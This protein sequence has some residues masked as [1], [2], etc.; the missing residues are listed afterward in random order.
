[1]KK[2]ISTI[3]A[4]CALTAALTSCNADSTAINVITR[5]EGSGTRGAFVELLEVTDASGVDAIIQSAESTGSTA[6]MITTVSGDKN[7][8]GYISLG[9]LSSDVK[10]VSLDG[11]AATVANV[12]NGTYSLVRPFNI[13]YKAESL[14]E[15]AAD[16]IAY[17][18]SK[19]GQ[20]I[21][22]SKGYIASDDNAA[23]YTASGLTGKITLAG[24][25][26]VSPLMDKIA[27]AYKAINSGVEIEI[28]QTGSSAGM[29]SAMEG[30]CDIG[31]ASRELK[32][33]EK[34]VLTGKVIAQDG[35]AVIVN[36]DS[37]VNNLTSEQIKK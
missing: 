20:A 22:A 1:M 30:A 21:A 4:V 26:S 33:S 31:M 17:I 18:M 32:D 5:E 27:D 12:K 11:V 23:S 35:I 14:S 6:V 10:A 16:F 15:L 2:I 29:T 8:I 36:K 3:I 25:T 9:S 34:A 7:A 19:E 24:S 13:A 28:Q 37:K